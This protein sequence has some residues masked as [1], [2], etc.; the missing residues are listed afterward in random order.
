[1][2]QI[3]GVKSNE[4]WVLAMIFTNSI[5]ESTREYKR[6]ERYGFLS[7]GANANVYE[8]DF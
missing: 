5:T 1:M 4:I 6:F 3:N 7:I 8:I 2:F